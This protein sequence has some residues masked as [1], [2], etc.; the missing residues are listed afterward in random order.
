MYIGFKELKTGEM[1][2]RVELEL[3]YI[4]DR[5]E[6]M[7]T[8]SE[9]NRLVSYIIYKMGKH[10]YVIC[11]GAI[12]SKMSYERYMDLDEFYNN[13]T[14]L[15]KYQSISN[16]YKSGIIERM[17]ARYFKLDGIDDEKEDGPTLLFPKVRM[18]TMN[19]K[20]FF[21]IH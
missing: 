12:G 17:R 7:S 3:L 20:I 8:E 6:G 11:E 21:I 2:K 19:V 9:Y 14:D 4:N 15:P 18:D 10:G 5:L 16:K 1:R 13:I